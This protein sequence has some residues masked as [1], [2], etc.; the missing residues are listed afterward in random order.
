MDNLQVEQDPPS[1]FSINLNNYQAVNC[2]PDD[3]QLSCADGQ[4]LLSRDNSLDAFR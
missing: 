4:P 3:D 1:L 2:L